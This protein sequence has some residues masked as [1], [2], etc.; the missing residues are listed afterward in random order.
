PASPSSGVHVRRLECGA[1]RSFVTK[2]WRLAAM[3]VDTVRPDQF[4]VSPDLAQAGAIFNDATRLLDGGL[5]SQPRANNQTPYLGMY[6]ADISAVLADVNADLA[7]GA[8]V[9]VGDNAYALS[10]TDTVVLGDVV[11]QLQTLLNDAPNSVGNASVENQMHTAQLAIINDVNGDPSLAQALAAATYTGASTGLPNTGFQAL[12]IGADDGA[13]LA[14]AVAHG[15]TL[16][17][18]GAVF[19][20]ATDLAVGGLNSSNLSEFDGDMHVV[21]TGLTNLLHNPTEI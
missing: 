7:P 14:A 3:A 11:S 1:N 4:P 2:E 10:T 17:Q 18:I 6:T 9:T 8:M 21:A 20:A 12:P 19:N 16:A 15:A 13:A 5:W